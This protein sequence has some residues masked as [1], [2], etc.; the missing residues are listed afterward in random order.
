MA[1]M[2]IETSPRVDKL[3]ADLREVTGVSNGKLMQVALSELAVLLDAKSAGK[4]VHICL[5]DGRPE[6]ELVV[7]LPLKKHFKYE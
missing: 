6:S 3:L 7:P 1:K 5:A 4:I 2:K